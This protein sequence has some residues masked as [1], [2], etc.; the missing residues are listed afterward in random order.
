MNTCGKFWAFANHLPLDQVVTYWCEKSG[1]KN[2]NC[3]EAKKAAIVAGCERGMIEYSRSDGKTFDD[4]P[5]DLAQRGLLTIKRDSFDAWHAENFG[6][7]SP[8]PEKPLSTIERNTLLTI[9]AVL[10]EEARLDYS[11]PAKTANLIADTAAR[12][13]LAIG[14]STIEGHLKKIP[15]ALETRMK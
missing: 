4:P 1:F 5:H 15:G 14:E 3:K 7:E 2:I 8:L 10:C 6:E 13:G 11:K 12:M 9:I